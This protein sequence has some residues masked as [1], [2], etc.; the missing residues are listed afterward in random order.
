[1]SLRN[2]TQDRGSSIPPTVFWYAPLNRWAYQS[3]RGKRYGISKEAFSQL[4]RDFRTKLAGSFDSGTKTWTFPE[5]ELD[6]LKYYLSQVYGPRTVQYRERIKIDLTRPR[7]SS[8]DATTTF[9]ELTGIDPQG[10][11]ILDLKIIYRRAAMTLH[12]DRG[13]DDAKMALLNIAW[14][15]LKSNGANTPHQDSQPY[16]SGEV[17]V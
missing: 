13:G 11:S 8:F 9:L 5:G 14:D 15:K 12:S 1:M 4:V 2:R 16:D 6:S 7:D 17:S 10:K 3:G